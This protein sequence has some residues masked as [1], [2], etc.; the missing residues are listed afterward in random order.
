MQARKKRIGQ[1]GGERGGWDRKKKKLTKNCFCMEGRI[2]K[3]RGKGKAIG[4]TEEKVESSKKK[5]STK[6]EEKKRRTKIRG[7]KRVHAIIL[8]QQKNKKKGLKGRTN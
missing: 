4:G 8:Y 5:T 3:K 1:G 6:S 7:E 2:T